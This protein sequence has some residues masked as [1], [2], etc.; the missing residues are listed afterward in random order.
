MPNASGV[1]VPPRVDVADARSI[2]I[3]SPSG[4]EATRLKFAVRRALEYLVTLTD[5][6]VGQLE[7]DYLHMK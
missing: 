5:G 1:N 7:D 2:V 3:G 4:S 6:M